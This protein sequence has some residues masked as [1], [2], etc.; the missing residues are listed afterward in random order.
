MSFFSFIFKYLRKTKFMAF[1]ILIA[2]IFR[3]IAE[4]GQV[5]AMAQVI[6]LLPQYAE[7]KSVL[8]GVCDRWRS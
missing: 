4:R 8:H 2:L 6:G 1:V 7:D 5:Y 3:S